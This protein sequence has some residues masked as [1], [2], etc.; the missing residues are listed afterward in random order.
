MASL[1]VRPTHHSSPLEWRSIDRFELSDDR[2][3]SL[4]RRPMSYKPFVATT[5]HRRQSSDPVCLARETPA[6]TNAPSEC[7]ALCSWCRQRQERDRADAAQEAARIGPLDRACVTFAVLSA[8]A[9]GYEVYVVADD[10]CGGVTAASHELARRRMER[11]GA[12]LTS[13][14]QVLLELQ[15]DWTRHETYDAARAIVES[16]G[17]GYGNRPRLCARH[18]SSRLT[19]NLC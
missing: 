11:A 10:A 13:W 1:I 16:H 8:L 5:S 19:E 2:T 9:N 3:A 14:I 17:G 4:K 7:C 18:D 12:Q 15:R 6:V